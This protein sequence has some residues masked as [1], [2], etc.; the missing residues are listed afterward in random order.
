MKVFLGGTHNG[1]L[2]RQELIPLLR[3]DYYN[4]IVEG[5]YTKAVQKEEIRQRELCDICLYVITPRMT[6]LYAIAEAVD[7]SNKRPEKTVF[8]ILRSDFGENQFD[9]LV[10][11]PE[12][13]KSLDQVARLIIDNGGKAFGSLMDVTTFLN[14]LAE[15]PGLPEYL[16]PIRTKK[17][18]CRQHWQLK[19]EENKKDDGK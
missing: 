1:S 6:G 4:P 2:W 7:D 15:G 9:S 11:M 12:Q 3:I 8:C 14:S 5:D 16:K 13:M 10:F 18:R 19:K 17:N